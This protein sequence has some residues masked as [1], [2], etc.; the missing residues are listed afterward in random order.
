MTRTR[1]AAPPT[2]PPIAAETLTPL[3]LLLPALLESAPPV[4]A[5]PLLLEA[6]GDWEGESERVVVAAPWLAPELDV[7]VEDAAAAGVGDVVER[8]GQTCNRGVIV[9]CHSC[10]YKWG[11]RPG[12]TCAAQAAP[13]GTVAL[14]AV[15]AL[16]VKPGATKY[17][18]LPQHGG[19]V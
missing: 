5:V 11:R 2:P 12:L 15:A 7:D 8:A 1:N 19:G 3:A 18:S 16:S 17:W 4:P 14:A 13:D 9:Y 10:A 6:D